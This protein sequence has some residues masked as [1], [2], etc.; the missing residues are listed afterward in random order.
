MSLFTAPLQKQLDRVADGLHLIGN[1][2]VAFTATYAE[3]NKCKSFVASSDGPF[4]RMVP[5]PGR[6]ATSV[7]T[8]PRLGA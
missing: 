3:A 4:H 6:E 8:D 7:S 2:I 1:A 5:A